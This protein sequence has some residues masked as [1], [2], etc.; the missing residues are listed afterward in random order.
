MNRPYITKLHIIIEIAALLICVASIILAVFYALRAGGQVPTN[1]DF[2]GNVTGYGSPWTALIMP[3][4]ALTMVITDAVVLHLV[5]ASSWNTGVRIRA[6]RANA[7]YKEIG[8]MVALLSLEFAMFAL[9]FTVLQYFSKMGLTASLSFI[10]IG[11]MTAT[12]VLA[13]VRASRKN[14]L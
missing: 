12:I 14:R 9:A 10:L 8:L 1:Y 6:G 7:V 4:V 13:I 11:V 3:L 2:Q 5:P